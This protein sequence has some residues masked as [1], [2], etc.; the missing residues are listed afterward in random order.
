MVIISSS[1]VVF[2]APRLAPRSRRSHKDPISQAQQ[3]GFA[4]TITGVLLWS[5]LKLQEQVPWA[6]WLHTCGRRS[7]SK[8]PSAC[9]CT[10]IRKGPRG[11]EAA[12]T[13]RRNRR[14]CLENRSA[15]GSRQGPN[16][17]CLAK[18]GHTETSNSGCDIGFRIIWRERY[19]RCG[20][21]RHQGR[22]WN[23]PGR[24]PC[25]PSRDPSASAWGK[26]SL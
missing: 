8:I 1:S 5:R 9:L 24:R 13:R 17:P 4:V 22:T 7:A 12:L 10:R 15:P 23:G 3:V 16:D 11:S 26:P 20:Q 2:G 19:D 25:S 18:F 14:R 6:A 21:G